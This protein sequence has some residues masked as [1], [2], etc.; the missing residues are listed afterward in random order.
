M[1][2]QFESQAGDILLW[3]LQN[4]TALVK[5]SMANEQDVG[6][7]SLSFVDGPTEWWVR[8][9]SQMRMAFARTGYWHREYFRDRSQ[10]HQLSY[11]HLRPGEKS[12]SDG[13]SNKAQ[14]FSFFVTLLLVNPVTSVSRSGHSTK[15]AK[16]RD[17]RNTL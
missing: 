11:A 13:L 16:I 15:S 8:R 2:A 14:C 3:Q 10:V 17:T 6:V 5:S 1:Q 7:S 9:V 4:S 12:Q